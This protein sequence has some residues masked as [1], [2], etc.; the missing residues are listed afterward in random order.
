MQTRLGLT[1]LNLILVNVTVDCFP[2]GPPV[3]THPNI[4]QSMFSTGH[5]ASTETSA[6]PFKIKL[7]NT[8]HKSL[9]D[10][11]GNYSH[12]TIIA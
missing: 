7:G 5:N 6:S 2:D 11:Q 4:C 9:M 8:C 10:L 12:F 3:E 1:M